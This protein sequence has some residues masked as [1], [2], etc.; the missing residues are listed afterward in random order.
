MIDDIL[1]RK[2]VKTK[3]KRLIKLAES[4]ISEYRFMAYK[5]SGFLREFYNFHANKFEKKLQEALK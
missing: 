2:I 4:G 3:D 5:S 1:I